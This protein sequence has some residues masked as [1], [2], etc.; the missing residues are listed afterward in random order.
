MIS[1]VGQRWDTLQLGSA[2]TLCGWA[3]QGYSAVGHCTKGEE[4]VRRPKAQQAQCEGGEQGIA[5]LVYLP[6][7]IYRPLIQKLVDNNS[8]LTDSKGDSHHI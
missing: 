8:N 1:A 6:L 4:N 2:G 3:L 7:L 5:D